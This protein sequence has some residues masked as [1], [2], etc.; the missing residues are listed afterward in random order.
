MLCDDLDGWDEELREVQEGREVCALI[1][2][3]KQHHGI[4]KGNEVRRG[5]HPFLQAEYAREPSLVSIL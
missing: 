4:W 1:D 2:F 3:I 5:G